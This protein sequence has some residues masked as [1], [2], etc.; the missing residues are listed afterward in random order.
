MKKNT[1]RI[2]AILTIIWTI[3]IFSFSLQPGE[4]SSHT[5]AGVGQ[6][7]IETFVPELA[8]EL[9][10]M[11]KD[12]LA[13]LHFILRKCAHFTEYFILGILSALTVWH[14]KISRE[15]IIIQVASVLIFSMCIAS[16]DETLQLYVPGRSG[17]FADVLLD[18]TGAAIG[19]L[20]FCLAINIRKFIL[21]RK[22]N[23][24]A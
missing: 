4:V 12:E 17:R 13:D 5:S 3:V 1:I 14:S 11:P 19:L 23:N 18:G 20:I 24:E 22:K 2:Y 8:E 9:E 16:I 10:S 6:W 21:E 15:G 7:I